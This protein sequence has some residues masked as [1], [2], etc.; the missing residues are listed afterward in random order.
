MIN[1][2][3]F[4][5]AELDF[6]RI[7][8]QIHEIISFLEYDPNKVKSLPGSL[9][10]SHTEVAVRPITRELKA[11]IKCLDEARAQLVRVAIDE[12]LI[13]IDNLFSHD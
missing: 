10:A 2:E 8:K 9:L 4:A 13:E 12:G 7:E 1:R 3:T 6:S 5:S 11:I